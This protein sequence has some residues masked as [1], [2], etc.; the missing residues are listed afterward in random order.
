VIYQLFR[1]R[2]NWYYPDFGVYA[3]LARTRKNGQEH[4]FDASPQLDLVQWGRL[5]GTRRDA[6]LRPEGGAG[7]ES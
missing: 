2:H 5:L 6:S 3:E 4:G 7:R 1:S